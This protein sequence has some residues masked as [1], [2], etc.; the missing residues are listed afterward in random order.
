M[1]IDYTISYNYSTMDYAQLSQKFYS[2]RTAIVVIAKILGW[3]CRSTVLGI[4]IFF[5]AAEVAIE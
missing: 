5:L 2:G 1:G 4:Q 3:P